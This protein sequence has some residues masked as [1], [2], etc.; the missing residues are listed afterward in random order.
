MY[1]DIITRTILPFVRA[2]ETLTGYPVIVNASFNMKDEP[3]VCAPEDAYHCFMKTQ[4][5]VL[6]LETHVILKP[7]ARLSEPGCSRF[8]S[9]ISA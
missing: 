8:L 3:I 9:V 4:V 2:F 6:I 7:A 1:Y 5:D